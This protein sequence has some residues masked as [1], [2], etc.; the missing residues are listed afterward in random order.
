[1]SFCLSK[2]IHSFI[3]PPHLHRHPATHH[4][5]P[6]L[7]LNERN[8][9]FFRASDGIFTNYCWKEDEPA[10][11]AARAEAAAA[12]AADGGRSRRWDVFMGIDCFGRNTYGG[13]GFDCDV[14][15]RA[16]RQ[17]GVS[18]ALF[19]PGW[20]WEDQVERARRRALGEE[21][22]VGREDEKEGEGEGET[23]GA[24]QEQGEG[25]GEA[26]VSG[27]GGA[28]SA[29][30]VVEREEWDWRRVEAEFEATQERFWAK[31]GAMWCVGSRVCVSVAWP[32]RVVADVLPHPPPNSLTHRP[33]R[34]LPA[35][36]SKPFVTNFGT[37]VGLHV[38]AGGVRVTPAFTFAANASSS[39]STGA[40]F[41]AGP[42]AAGGG[43]HV[44]PFYNLAMQDALPLALTHCSRAAVKQPPPK[45]PNATTTGGGGRVSGRIGDDDDQGDTPPPCPAALGA[46]TS[47]RTAYRGGS[48]LCVSGLLHP[49]LGATRATLPLYA[50]DAPAPALALEVR[51]VY[52][53]P[54]GLGED[55]FCLELV[56]QGEGVAAGVGG[57]EQSPSSS[58]GVETVGAMGRLRGALAAT[59]IATHVILRPGEEAEGGSSSSSSSWGSRRVGK[60]LETAKG[61]KRT[62]KIFFAPVSDAPVGAAGTAAEGD[63]ADVMVMTSAQALAAT[64][65]RARGSSQGPAAVALSLENVYDQAALEALPWRQ[66]VFRVRDLALEGARVKELR[67]VC[68]KKPLHAHTGAS[69]D[70]DDPLPLPYCLFVGELSLGQ[71][72]KPPAPPTLA[73]SA[74]PPRAPGPSGCLLLDPADGAPALQCQRLELR[75]A[76]WDAASRRL[77][78]QVAWG[79]AWAAEGQQ[80]G[81][82]GALVADTDVLLFFGSGL[83]SAAPIWVGRTFTAAFALS[84]ALPEGAWDQGVRLVL[85]PR[86][87]LG[88]VVPL[89][90][91]SSLSVELQA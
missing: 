29:A 12:A 36:L 48:S 54:H 65:A 15:L 30:S 9:A 38:W 51:A 14:A 75:A 2:P 46:S 80:G 44:T 11:S 59:S 28:A 72:R 17:A 56:L 68:L 5:A 76:H 16:I 49:G 84:I 71:V 32:S 81:D 90:S 78:G 26:P 60:T 64:V 86:D 10:R 40:G 79:W 33:R 6:A 42:K 7:A 22:G 53:A 83:G 21:E 88:S 24:Q 69:S 58:V 62:R 85:Q 87:R 70:D 41:A 23:K 57:E 73:P 3:H 67:L 66:R 61:A 31:I 45:R 20:V 27:G 37:G 8:E 74:A 50:L 63:D 39:P 43:E 13:G 25:S 35:D 82:P 19:A 4:N 91:C 77:S 34:P 1:M 89:C 18:A 47:Y 55:D 52:K